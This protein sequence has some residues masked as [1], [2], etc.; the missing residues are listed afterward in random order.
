MFKFYFKTKE[1]AIALAF[2]ISCVC[3]CECGQIWHE[4]DIDNTCFCCCLAVMF[5]VKSQKPVL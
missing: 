3:K 2:Q 1:M 5:V 4:L